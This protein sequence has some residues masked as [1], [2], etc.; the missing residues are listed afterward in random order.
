MTQ[1]Y[2]PVLNMWTAGP[3]PPVITASGNAAA[4]GR[5]IYYCGGLRNATTFNAN[6]PVT[7]CSYVSPYGACPC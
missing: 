5:A 6:A 2:N 7:N 4:I 3:P 1:I